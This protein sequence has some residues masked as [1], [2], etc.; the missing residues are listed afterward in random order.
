[1]ARKSVT[2]GSRRT[3]EQIEHDRAIRERFQRDK[4]SLAAL[5]AGGEYSAP[6]KQGEYLTLMEFASQ[7]KHT[8]EQMKL[9][10]ADVS[11]LSGLDRSAISRLENGLIENPTIGTLLK[12]AKSLG[13]RLRI[14]LEDDSAVGVR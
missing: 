7:V 5:V 2:Q 3:P 10:L 4:P 9:S 13:K 8:R 11:G 14:A 6:I 1:M 12:V